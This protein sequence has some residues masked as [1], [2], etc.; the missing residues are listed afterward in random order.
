MN[1]IDKARAFG[2]LHVKGTP[3]VLWNIWDAGSA[4]AVAKAGAPA[5]ATGSWSVAA[6]QGFADGE[7]LPLEAALQTARQIAGAVDLPV[8]VD[9]EGGYAE[10]P[11]D[12]ARN[13]QALME[14]GVIGLNI[15]DRVIGGAGLH[16]ASGQAA[17]IAAI[18]G[19][20][21]AAGIPFFINARTDVFF[22]GDTR[23]PADLLAEAVARAGVY[24]DAGADGLFVPGLADCDLIARLCDATRLPVNVMRLGDAHPVSRFAQAGVARISHGPGPYRAA[25]SALG[26]AARAFY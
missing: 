21:D 23:E 13:M 15:E 7:C 2:A 3:L 16:P 1:Q 20:A 18:R 11:A 5:L 6:A 12:V 10:D 19:V 22:S 4:Q 24:A 26:A 9:F 25:M 14:T 17:R 8:S